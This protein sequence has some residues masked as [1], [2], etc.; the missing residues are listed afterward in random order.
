MKRGIKMKI[1]AHR[2]GPGKYPEQTI[3]AASFSLELGADYVEMDI[4]FT[5]DGVPII[6][7]DPNALRIFGVDSDINRLTLTEFL[8]LRHASDKRYPSHTL[9]DVISCK[10]EPVLLHCKIT[11]RLIDDLLLHLRQFNYED[12]VI[13]GVYQPDDVSTIKSFNPGIKTLAFMQSPADSEAYIRNGVDFIRFWEQWLTTY[14]IESIINSGHKVWIMANTPGLGG[15]GH[16]TE[17]NILK[18][19][20]MGV[21][22]VLIDDVEWALK[23][24]P[25]I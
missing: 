9:S 11:G 14:D 8:S 5:S 4:R 20:G 15:V 7:H 6:C 22:G 12:K 25:K 3:A 13:L 24:F 1:I 21:D 16:T 18:W 2:C 23:V 19:A 17:E 10:I